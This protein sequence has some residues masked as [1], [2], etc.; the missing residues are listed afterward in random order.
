MRA[1]VMAIFLGACAR[2]GPDMPD[3]QAD[4]GVDAALDVQEAATLDVAVDSAPDA[5]SLDN[6]LVGL[7][8]LDETK[9]GTAAGGA[10]F[11]D[12]S[13]LG[14][15]GTASM[16]G[17]TFGV[18]GVFGKA[19]AFDGVAGYVTIGSS[20]PQPTGEMSAAAWIKANAT[21]GSFPQIV[22]AGDSTGVTGYNLYLYS[23]MSQGVPSFILKEGSNAWGSC[24]VTGTSDLRDGKWHHVVGVYA[25]TTISIYVDGSLQ[26]FTA[27]ANLPVTYGMTPIGEIA[28]KANGSVFAGA[29]EQVAVWNRALSSLEVTALFHG[30]SGIPL[31]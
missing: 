21:Q 3:A 25:A 24:W 28:A 19:A 13:G 2:S 7:W 26:A 14:H 31:P 4:A 12:T 20:A 30:G 22:A 8:N 1:T 27:C 9:A 10:D 18:P 5:G 11:A 23:P 17:V 29:L 6:G 16:S 15:P